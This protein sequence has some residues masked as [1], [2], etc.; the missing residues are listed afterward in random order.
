MASNLYFFGG[1]LSLFFPESFP[2]FLLGQLGGLTGGTVTGFGGVT[3]G[4]VTF[5]IVRNFRK[6]LPTHV[7]F[8]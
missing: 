1:L 4:L 7:L 8:G 6:L 5:A 3:A 2:I